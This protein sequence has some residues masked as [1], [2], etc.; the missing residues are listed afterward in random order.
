MV[1]KENRNLQRR[2][3]SIE[4]LE[5]AEELELIHL[6]VDYRDFL[7]RAAVAREPHRLTGYCESLA[8]AFHKF[9]H[10]R[11][12]IQ[13]DRELAL[14]RLALCHATRRVLAAA[15]G[16]MSIHAPQSM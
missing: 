4:R 10:E 14:A 6:L 1:R 8:R 12:V 5:Q 7:Q 2:E 16:L 3:S 15:L 11:R 9:Y 13:D